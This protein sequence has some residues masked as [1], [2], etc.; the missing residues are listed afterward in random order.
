MKKSKKL[1]S[2][3]VSSEKRLIMLDYD[4]T[5]ID[6]NDK[7]KLAI[8]SQKLKN[9]INDICKNENTDVY[10]ISGR[11]KILSSILMI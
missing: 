3:F 6:F 11:S 2:H 8:P 5:L 7:P 4:G 10:I 1:K 9:L